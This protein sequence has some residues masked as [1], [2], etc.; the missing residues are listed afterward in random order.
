[1]KLYWLFPVAAAVLALA[2][3]SDSDSS[4]DSGKE[5]GTAGI[6]E[7][8]SDL[9]SCGRL[10]EGDYA[11][12]GD[13]LYLCSE[14]KWAS[15]ATVIESKAELPKCTIKKEG[16]TVYLPDSDDLLVCEDDE[17]VPLDEKNE[18]D[19]E[20][21]SDKEP[22]DSSESTA[23]SSDSKGE[24]AESSSSDE[25]AYSSEKNSSSDSGKTE[26]VASSSSETTTSSSESK[27]EQGE[28]GEKGED[29][30]SCTATELEDGSGFT[31]SCGGMDVG[32]IKNGNDGKDGLDGKDGKDG[33]Y[34][35]TLEEYNKLLLGQ[36]G[37]GFDAWSY[38]TSGKNIHSNLDKGLDWSGHWGTYLDLSE[39]QKAGA[40]P[41]V[42]N[43]GKTKT[44]RHAPTTGTDSWLTIPEEQ[45]ENC[46]GVCG[47]IEYGTAPYPY[48][49]VK[50]NMG[51][52]GDVSGWLGVCAE[53]TSDV[54]VV[55]QLDLDY[56]FM[57]N[58][59]NYDSPGFTVPASSKTAVVNIPWGLMTQMGWGYAGKIEAR[60][61]IKMVKGINITFNKKE[62]LTASFNITKIGAYGTC[63]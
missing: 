18:E 27:G 55:I 4:T 9:P 23:P 26:P 30:T 35:L 33:V 51:A 42:V 20:S 49:S 38:A 61:A 2:A 21:S 59:I 8:E 57:V 37:T 1:M 48:V 19:I 29:G 16:V 40:T 13:E 46:N 44:Y 63:E 3:C 6:Y 17:W 14:K 24:M 47:T 34:E 52:P 36:K 22:V 31:L 43:F 53:Y 56:D 32:T 11:Q 7:S 15:I 58:V 10:N 60:D 45:L 5:K 12:V 25:V 41:S 39:S 54:D 62:S 28:Q 50:A